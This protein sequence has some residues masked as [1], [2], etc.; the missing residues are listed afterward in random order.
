MTTIGQFVFFKLQT[1]AESKTILTFTIQIRS[2]EIVQKG[3]GQ[4]V[5]PFKKTRKIEA[6]C[7]Q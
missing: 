1:F 3:F 5:P 7:I 2:I 4:S 6:Y